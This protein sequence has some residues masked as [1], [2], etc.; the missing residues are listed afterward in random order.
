MATGPGAGPGLMKFSKLSRPARLIGTGPPEPAV[1]LGRPSALRSL[2]AKRIQ[3][4]RMTPGANAGEHEPCRDVVR[5]WTAC[6]VCAPSGRPSAQAG[7][8]A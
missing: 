8:L 1:I 2:L 6:F 5:G 4:Y 3:L 7:C